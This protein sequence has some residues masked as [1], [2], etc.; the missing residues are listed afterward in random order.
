MMTGMRK[1]SLQA[2]NRKIF[3]CWS[4]TLIIKLR[5]NIKELGPNSC[6]INHYIDFNIHSKANVFKYIENK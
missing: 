1:I 6:K 5:T 2:T 3:V 4:V